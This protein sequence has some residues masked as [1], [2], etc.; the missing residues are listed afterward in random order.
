[1]RY[2]YTCKCYFKHE[3]KQNKNQLKECK[4]IFIRSVFFLFKLHT[5]KMDKQ[6]DNW[7]SSLCYLV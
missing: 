4:I 3:K 5:G 2:P 7:P 6:G 1:M